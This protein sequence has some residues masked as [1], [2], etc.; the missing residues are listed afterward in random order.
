MNRLP[1]L[2]LAWLAAFALPVSAQNAPPVVTTQIG[3]FTEYAGAPPRSIE[4]LNYFVDPDVSAAVRMTTVLGDV[5]L[6]LFGQQKPITVTN[7]LRYVDQGRYFLF[8]PTINQT[9]SSFIHRSVPGFVIQG[10]GYIGTVD[11]ADP[12]KQNAKPIQVAS[13]GPIQNE[14]GISNTRGTI[15]MAKVAGDPNSAT[16]EWFINLADNNSGSNSLDTQNG[17]F[18][19]F[20]KIVHNTMSVVDSIAALPRVNAG[21]PFDSL[22]LRNYTAPNPIKVSNLVSIPGIARI[23]TLGFSASSDN[24]NVSV[25]LSGTKLLVTANTLGTSHITV[26]ATDFDGAT[27]SQSFTVTV[28]AAPGRLVNLSTRLRVGTGDNAMIA[29]FIVRGSADKRL[30]LRAIG[31]SSGL[32]GAIPNPILELHDASTTIATNDNW[33]DAAN[34]QDVSDLNLA[35]GSPAESVILT[36]VR[37]SSA[38]IIYTAVMKDVNNVN[39]LGVVEIYDVDSGPGSTMLNISTRG[40]VGADP[41]ALIG[42]FVLG[43]TEWKQIL[44]RAIGPSLSAFNVN[45]AI[46]NPTLDFFNAQ[47]TKLDSNDDWVNSPQKAQIQNSGLAPTDSK[48]SAIIQTLSAGFFTAVVHAVNGETGVGSVEIY[49]LP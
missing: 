10:G 12:N 45:N 17:G 27:V 16:S 40:P 7:F 36:T 32:S 4:L 2:L 48:E 8:D 41:N 49:Q 24:G 44:V 11:P 31:V 37:A 39:G 46:T 25:A 6:A 15:A 26:T 30:A 1:L 23:P 22:P 13:F 35:P 18:T 9:A 38:G 43:G 42:G 5:D 20:G 28:V 21:A 33:G 34:R 29:G 14:P 3:D 47:G 19:V